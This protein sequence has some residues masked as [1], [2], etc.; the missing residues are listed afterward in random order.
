MRDIITTDVITS[1]V[2]WHEVGLHTN[3][4]QPEFS[5]TAMIEWCDS[6][7]S[8]GLYRKHFTLKFPI[9]QGAFWFEHSEDAVE[10]RLRW[11]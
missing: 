6:H 4:N 8:T 1:Q 3:I 9:Y 7:P 11:L 10:F 5:V 2:I